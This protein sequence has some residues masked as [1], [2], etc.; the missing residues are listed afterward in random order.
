[1]KSKLNLALGLILLIGLTACEKD[2]INPID[3]DGFDFGNQAV[4]T[5]NNG[6]IKSYSSDA[7]LKWSEALAV[8]LDNT[9]PQPADAK[10]Y[11]MVSLAVHDALNNVVPKYETYAMDNTAVNAKDITKKNIHAIADAAVAQA[12][13][14][15]LVALFPP[16]QATFGPLLQSSLAE[17]SDVES[18]QKGIA[19]GKDAAASL[20]LKRQGDF[21][22]MFTT[23][24]GPSG[25]GQYQSDFLPWMNPG[26]VWPANA[27]YAPNLGDLTPFGI[28]FGDQFR[29]EAPYPIN[30][31][32][33][34]ADYNEVK[35]LGCLVCPDRTAEQEEIGMFWIENNS[36]L[37]ARISRSL[38]A[39]EK[40][41]GWEAARLIALVE[42]SIMDAYIASFEGKRYFNL[43]RPITAIRNGDTDGNPDT[44]GDPSW[45]AFERVPP[46]P[47]FPSTHSYTGGAATAVFQS[48][49]KKDVTPFE[50]ES[51]YNSPGVVRTISS[52]SQIADENATSRIY[53]GYHFRYATTL[54]KKQGLELGKYV[55]DNNLRELQNLH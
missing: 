29:N 53:I 6:I 21:P 8:A 43:W 19:I 20:L 14:D 17:I 55:F 15:V 25:P 34:T 9:L 38:I 5:Y 7:V 40:L 42:M 36:S 2:E 45:T 23:H 47:E 16:S 1:M 26:P 52:F 41:N 3:N 11:V 39:Q 12:A 33:Y 10:I 13:H 37:M 4:K 54:G 48:F 31:A 27:V 32:E 35:A 49:F 28:R 22:L 18:K 50:V 44:V 51:P 46:T 24:V 30:S